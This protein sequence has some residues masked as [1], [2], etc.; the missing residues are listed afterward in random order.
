[1][2]RRTITAAGPVEML[3][4]KDKP[5]LI[6][7]YA[8]RYHD[9]NDAGTEYQLW[10]DVFERIMPGAFDRA[11]RDDDVRALFNHD[12]SSVLGRSK[13]GTLRLSLDSKGLRYEI[14]PP[15]TQV[16]RDVLTILHR[17]DVSGS[18]FAFD[19]LGETIRKETVDGKTRY[20]RELTDVK[21]FDVGPVT[22]PAYNAADSGAR[23]ATAA[24]QVRSAA[25]APRDR[26]R[27]LASS[28]T[29]QSALDK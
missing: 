28:M 17:G 20:I 19:I 25:N 10:D 11:V 1:M 9:P 2:I 13:S 6:A 14:D 15:D 5:P 21:L 24:G 22:F 26:L 12:P 29:M 18:S 8:A 3:S 4:R 16:G 23:S 27:L 7:G